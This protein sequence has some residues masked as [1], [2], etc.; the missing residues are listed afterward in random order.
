MRTTT[1]S[2]EGTFLDA[3]GFVLVKAR[4]ELLPPTV[5]TARLS[6]SSTK[7]AGSGEREEAV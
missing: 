6:Q 5:A 2:Q 7:L 4:P 1:G 3:L